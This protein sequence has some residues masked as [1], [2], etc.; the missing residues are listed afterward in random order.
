MT[1]ETNRRVDCIVKLRNRFG[2]LVRIQPHGSHRNYQLG[3]SIFI[4]QFP[5]R[6]EIDS[7]GGLPVRETALLHPTE[8]GRVLDGFGFPEVIQMRMSSSELPLYC[9]FIVALLPLS[10]RFTRFFAEF[11]ERNCRTPRPFCR[12]SHAG[13]PQ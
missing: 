1:T 11:P 3:G 4:R 2:K 5:R 7:P 6:L 13:G 9:R 12:I 8:G 10:V